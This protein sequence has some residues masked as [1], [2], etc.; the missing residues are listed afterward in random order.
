MYLTKIEIPLQSRLAADC[1]RNRQKMHALITRM[2]NSSQ[3]DNHIQYRIRIHERIL[4]AYIYSDSTVV[5][6]INPVRVVAS[7]N[8]GGWIDGFESGQ[9]IRFDLYAY[10]SK[11][12]REEGKKNSRRVILDSVDERVA[13]LSKKGVQYGYEI[14][15]VTEVAPVKAQAYHAEDRGGIMHLNGYHYQG[16]LRI[17][18]KVLFKEAI[19]TGV[20]PE[21]AYGFGM[22]LVRPGYAESARTSQID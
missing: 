19:R 13:W 4:S 3:S 6:N 7:K 20:G 9:M 5:E 22:L 10:P 2:F 1:L 8:I 15:S 18:D 21:K 17:T 16:V 12:I 14:E 11:K